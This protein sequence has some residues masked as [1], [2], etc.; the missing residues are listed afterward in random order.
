MNGTKSRVLFLAAMLGFMTSPQPTLAQVRDS[1]RYTRFQF[2][3]TYLGI[4]LY[5]L[6]ASGSIP[7][8]EQ[9]ETAQTTP[10]YRVAPRINIGGPHFWGHAE[11]FVNIPVFN[12]TSGHSPADVSLSTGTE[13][14]FACIHGQYISTNSHLLPAFRGLQ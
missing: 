2:A 6:P 9:G 8:Y 10:R 13:T 5:N 4:D 1:V 11:F 12:L 7:Y 3:Q 14:G